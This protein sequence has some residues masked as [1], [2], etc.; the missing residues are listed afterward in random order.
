MPGW[1]SLLDLAQMA[2]ARRDGSL[3]PA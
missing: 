1:R 2:K 3:R